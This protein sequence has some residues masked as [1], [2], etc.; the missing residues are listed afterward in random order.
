MGGFPNNFTVN[1]FAVSGSRLFAAVS[2][3]TGENRDRSVWTSTDNGQT[4]APTAFNQ[5]GFGAQAIAASG[6]TVW[7]GG[8]GFPRGL[9]RST[10][11]G[12]T[13]APLNLS[14]ST[15]PIPTDN[16]NSLA[17]S[18]STLLAL[19]GGPPTL[20]VSTNAGNTWIRTM[21]G[22]PVSNASYPNPFNPST[23][24][25]YQLPATSNVNLKVFDMLGREVA[26]L[27]NERQ[28]AGQYQ[29]RFDATRLASGMYFYR[30][31]AGSFIETKKMMLVK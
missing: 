18:G 30:L 10:D 31:Q 2:I 15:D 29:V 25:T 9:F 19:G 23:T 7:V 27:V 28:N 4:W 1:D 14:G 21:S 24:I 12:T 8:I 22:L 13:W 26:T 5:S 3:S 16:V 20:F 11:N 6:N 17:V